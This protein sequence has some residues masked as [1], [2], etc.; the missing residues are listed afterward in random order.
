M[1]LFK[2]VIA[3]IIKFF[4]YKQKKY[5]L[6]FFQSILREGNKLGAFPDEF[7]IFEKAE[8]GRL[9]KKRFFKKVSTV[10]LTAFKKI[11]VAVFNGNT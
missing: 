6:E 7:L 2:G 8:N 3:R 1:R 10:N 4:I 5:N 9:V 11:F